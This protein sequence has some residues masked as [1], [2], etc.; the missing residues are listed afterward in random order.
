VLAVEVQDDLAVGVRLE[1]GALVLEPLAQR[2]VVV[3][4][5]VDGKDDLAV[6]GDERLG[7]GV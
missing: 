2:A 4:L 7:T 5:A 1:L 6:G 3:D